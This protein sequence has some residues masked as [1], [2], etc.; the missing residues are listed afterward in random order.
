M[1][2]LPNSET[3]SYRSRLRAEQAEETRRRI[4]D[5]AMR[6]IAKG[7]LDISVPAI[8]REAGVSVATVYRHFRTKRDL[9]GAVY[10][11]AMRSA[12]LR[13]VAAPRTL[14]E[15]HDSVVEDFGQLDGLDEVTRAAMASPA[16][17][18]VRRLSMPVRTAAFVRLADSI[19]PRPSPADRDRIARLLMILTGSS[20][21]RMWREHFG[22]TVDEAADDIDWI[23]RAAAAATREGAG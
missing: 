14:D 6:V 22:L 23:V 15:L 10:P 16:S 18:Q 11:H 1:T 4:L 13:E 17:E 21:Q 5:A 7:V 20:A 19:E 9:V 12:G 8:A 2:H 3:R